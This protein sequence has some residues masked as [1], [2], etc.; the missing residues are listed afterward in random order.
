M[1]S[2]PIDRKRIDSKFQL[3]PTARSWSK[4]RPKGG[5]KRQKKERCYTKYSM[6]LWYGFLCTLKQLSH[7]FMH[8]IS[9]NAKSTIKLRNNFNER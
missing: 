6:H 7:K 5:R 1:I 4:A 9:P 8:I 3:D 2:V